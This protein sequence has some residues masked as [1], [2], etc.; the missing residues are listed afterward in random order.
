MTLKLG[1]RE[2]AVS[3]AVFGGVMFALVSV[4]PRV[5]DHVSDLVGGSRGSAAPWGARA[6][7]A[8]RRALDRGAVPEHR[9]RAA[10]GVRHRRRGADRLHVEELSAAC[11]S[12]SPSNRTCARPP[13]SS[14]SSARRCS[15]TS[16]S[17][18]RATPRSQAM[19]TAMPDVLLL[20]AL[21]SPRDEDELIAHLR[22]LDDADHLQTHTIPQLASA[23]QPGEERG[24]A[25]TAV[26]VPP[27]EGS[28]AGASGCDPDMFAEEI[29]C[30]CSAPPTRSASMQNSNRE[31]PDMRPSP[32]GAAP[33]VHE[34]DDDSVG[35]VFVLVVAIR[36]EARQRRERKRDERRSKGRPGAAS[37]ECGGAE[38]R[39]TLDAGRRVADGASASPRWNSERGGCRPLAPTAQRRRWT[40]RR[41]R[42]STFWCRPLRQ[43]SR[44][45][46]GSPLPQ[47][48]RL[49]LA[50]RRRRPN[51]PRAEPSTSNRDRWSRARFRLPNRPR[52]QCRPRQRARSTRSRRRSRASSHGPGKPTPRQPL[53]TATCSQL[54]FRLRPTRRR[55]KPK[56]RLPTPM[57]SRVPHRRLKPATCSQGTLRLRPTQRRLKPRRR[58]PPPMRSSV[59]HQGSKSATCSQE[60]LRLHPTQ[61][62]LKPRRRSRP[63]LQ[64]SSP[65]Q[66]SK[67]CQRSR[68]RPRSKC[69][70][71]AA[72]RR[73][74]R[75]I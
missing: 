9:Q 14:G 26:G 20:S 40:T 53:K 8:R 45:T 67:S 60:P 22:T 46:L 58:S 62:R 71:R 38:H 31:M 19:R 64:L 2:G 34:R 11:H 35:A 68:K 39:G 28:G 18:T 49:R 70:R 13:S 59:P 48:R 50:R 61:R 52:R 44:R 30:S 69:P 1:I 16:P 10:A 17:S 57:R 73:P 15:P 47:R 23:L 24:A 43:R 41:W 75:S 36:V 32:A 4:D 21:L 33:A 42:R 74:P 3:A 37:L 29:R 72:A 56:R 55:S 63:P 7:R 27:Q 51:S 54:P 25:R 66:P 5:R 6:Q 12:F 65:R